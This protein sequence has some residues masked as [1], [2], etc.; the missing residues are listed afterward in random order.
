MLRSPAAYTDL[1]ERYGRMLP[2]ILLAVGAVLMVFGLCMLWDW[3]DGDSRWFDA[4]VFERSGSSKNDRQFLDLY[5]VAI[6]LAP[7]LSGAI[8]IV[9]GL[10]YFL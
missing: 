5:Y 2:L 7:L 3:V 10:C 1:L 6:V 8:L 9:L 4:G